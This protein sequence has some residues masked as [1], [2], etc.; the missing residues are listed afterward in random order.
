[1]IEVTNEETQEKPT[2][3][4]KNQKARFRFDEDLKAEIQNYALENEIK[5]S[6]AIR[7]LVKL[8][9]TVV[10]LKEQIKNLKLALKRFFE[11]FI[12]VDKRKGLILN[13]TD[14]TVLSEIQ[15]MARSVKDE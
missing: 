9:L 10:K 8:G 5:E 14:R 2:K 6:E 4:T 13:N 1:M 11:L 12:A 15:Q 7:R 3:K